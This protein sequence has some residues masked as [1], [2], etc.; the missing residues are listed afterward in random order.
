MSGINT[1]AELWLEDKWKAINT[2]NI[3]DNLEYY[4]DELLQ[5]L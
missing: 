2:T 1:I 5:I 3:S 4:H